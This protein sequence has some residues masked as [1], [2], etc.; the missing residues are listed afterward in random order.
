MEKIKLLLYCT[1]QRKLLLRDKE[2]KAIFLGITSRVDRPN[3]D[4]EYGMNCAYERECCEEL[5][6][7]IIAEC[8]YEVEEIEP[9]QYQPD[10]YGG[11]EIGYKTKTLTFEELLKK[12]CLTFEKLDKY[13]YCDIGYTIHIKNIDIFNTPREFLGGKLVF[14]KELKNTPQNMMYCYGK[15][16]GEK[17]ILISIRPEW[18]CKILNGEKTIEVRKKVLKEMLNNDL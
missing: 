11:I 4:T 1:K 6:G 2:N 16:T 9:Y 7:K 14:W 17:Y 5:N 3:Y 10:F 13:L 12:S 15:N 8:E 18:L